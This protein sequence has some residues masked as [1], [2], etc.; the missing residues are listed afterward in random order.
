V[1]DLVLPR[2]TSAAWVLG[3]FVVALAAFHLVLVLWRPL[4][5]VAW[6]KVDYVWLSLALLGI[7]FGAGAARREVAAN[8][9]STAKSRLEFAVTQVEDRLAFGR[10][11]AVCRKFV[12]SEFSPPPQEFDRMQREFD[13]ECAWFRSATERLPQ[14]SFARRE[15][16]RLEELGSSPP[17]GGDGWAISSLQD[18][19]RRYNEA[20]AKSKE[21]SG[22][23]QRPEIES[24]LAVIGPPLLAVALALRIT[25]VTGEIWRDTRAG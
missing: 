16:L 18:S 25:K 19:I 21:L 13:A 4:S 6:K 8:M 7:V 22:A 9:A 23:M 11:P 24:I 15:V 1:D 2:V 20:A 14:T 5:I 12:R 10:G 17:Q 3:T